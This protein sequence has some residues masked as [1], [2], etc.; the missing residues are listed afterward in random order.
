M[1][2]A[3]AGDSFTFVITDGEAKI[4]AG[5][6]ISIFKVDEVADLRIEESAQKQ[7]ADDF[8]LNTYR[9]DVLGK[10]HEDVSN[11][12]LPFSMGIPGPSNLRGRDT[13]L[14]TTLGSTKDKK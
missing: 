1:V 11:R 5:T 3:S 2:N 12:V 7:I 14:I 13:A 9:A 6:A 10:Q 4:D 8:T